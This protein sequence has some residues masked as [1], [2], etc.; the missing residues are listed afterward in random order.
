MDIF[1]KF[2]AINNC[3]VTDCV[4]SKY[5]EN[6]CIQRKWKAGHCERNRCQCVTPNGAVNYL[7]DIKD[8]ELGKFNAYERLRHCSRG[9][10]FLYII[11]S[12]HF[13]I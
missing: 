6:E 1:K 8:Y 5:C 11:V 13:Y 9:Y 10:L 12:H 2:S 4:E 7:K 3:D